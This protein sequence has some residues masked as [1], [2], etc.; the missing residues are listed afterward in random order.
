VR[1]RRSPSL[2]SKVRDGSKVTKKYD[3]VTTPPH[4]RAERHDA[5]TNPD[6]AILAD[7]YAALTTAEIQRQIQAL[8]A[9]LLRETTP[10]R[11]QPTA[12]P[13]SLVTGGPSRQRRDQRGAGP[14]RLHLLIELT[15]HHAHPR[16]GELAKTA[17]MTRT[18][19]AYWEDQQDTPVAADSSGSMLDEIVR[20]GAR[21][22][23]AAALEAEVAAYVAEHTDQLDE[24]GRRLVAR[25]G[26]HQARKVLTS[27][28]AIE[29]VA[30]RVNDK[31]INEAT[32]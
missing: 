12:G 17:R 20:E 24:H 15:G 16:P 2:A 1:R 6:K 22:M 4:R 3:T 11:P 27:S 32:G 10:A 23:L 8:T 30:P 5:V 7:T 18:S 29:V 19:K 14:E 13:P 28:G 31:R 25:N 26:R 21:R 9:D